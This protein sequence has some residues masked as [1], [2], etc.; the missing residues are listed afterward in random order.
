MWS[1]CSVIWKR[2]C[3]F[4]TRKTVN[5]CYWKIGENN[6]VFLCSLI[7]ISMT[8]QMFFYSKFLSVALYLLVLFLISYNNDNLLACNLKCWVILVYTSL[9]L[10]SSNLEAGVCALA[11]LFFN[12]RKFISMYMCLF[13]QYLLHG[14]IQFTNIWIRTLVNIL[15]G[16]R[17]YFSKHL[18]TV[19]VLI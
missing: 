6:S 14:I 5:I 9:K 18:A 13:Q 16:S 12:F 17:T 1:I 7:L 15:E 3:W 2:K 4:D 10:K 19:H 8:D 11:N